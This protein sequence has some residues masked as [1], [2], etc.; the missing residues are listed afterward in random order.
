MKF[1]DILSRYHVSQLHYDDET[2][3][4]E[5]DYSD[6]FSFLLKYQMVIK[7]STELSSLISENDKKLIRKFEF[8]MKNSLYPLDEIELMDI[9]FGQNTNNVLKA[10]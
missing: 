8:A 4:S 2:E 6:L 7:N 1:K 10:D 9:I 3:L 5:K